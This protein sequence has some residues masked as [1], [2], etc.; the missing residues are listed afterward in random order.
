MKKNRVGETLV[1]VMVAMTVIAIAA[2]FLLGGI[3]SAANVIKRGVDI[4]AE[5][6][7]ATENIEK[8]VSEKKDSGNAEVKITINGSETEKTVKKISVSNDEAPF[9]S[10]DYYYTE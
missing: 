7:T 6:E 2:L 3:S 9:I 5:N 8:A 1:E 10:Y 4:T